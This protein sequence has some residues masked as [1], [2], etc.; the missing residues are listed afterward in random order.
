MSI[1][2]KK[3]VAAVNEALLF[4]LS[5]E[6]EAKSSRTQATG[7]SFIHPN[8]ARELLRREH[9]K[10]LF[11]SLSWYEE[12][13]RT[14][15]W[16]HMSLILCVLISMGWR[17]WDAFQTY[18]FYP[19]RGLKYPRYTDVDLPIKREAFVE[20]V[21]SE[22]LNLFHLHQYRFMPIFI[23]ENSHVSYGTDY[24]LPILMIEPLR[25]AIGAQGVVEK[26][27]IEKRYLLYENGAS[28]DSVGP[29]SMEY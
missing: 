15:I 8:D 13:S 22:F 11:S 16:K 20:K 1:F 3:R 17:E 26:I 4:R 18:F 9:I 19:G 28:N 23:K 29:L 6:L 27:Q 12:D 2:S 7:H 25:D 14:E 21:P 5:S 24:R 10:D